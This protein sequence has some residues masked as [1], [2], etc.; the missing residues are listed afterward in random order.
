MQFS[1]ANHL[2]Y[3]EWLVVIVYVALYA[4]AQR[5]AVSM[6]SGVDPLGDG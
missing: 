6:Q 1:G 2:S 4:A 5:T 3:A